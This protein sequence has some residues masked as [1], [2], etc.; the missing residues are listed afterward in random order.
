MTTP[1]N[2]I[3]VLQGV[4]P[5]QIATAPVG[6]KVVDLYD[7]NGNLFSTSQVA[8]MESGGGEVLGYFSIGEAENF[9]SYFSTLPSSIVGPVDPDW[10]GDY[11]VAYW[12]PQWLTV[13]ENYIQTMI[14]QGYNGAFFDVV[15]EAEQSWAIKNVP[16][17]TF[18]AAEGAMV[19]L[20]QELA[21]Y[22]HAQDPNFKIWINSGGAEDMLGDSR[23]QRQLVG[24]RHV[25]Q[26]RRQRVD[27]DRHQR[28][29]DRNLKRSHFYACERGPNGSN[30]GD[31]RY[32]PVGHRRRRKCQLGH[33]R[34]GAVFIHQD[35]R[36]DHGP[37][38]VRE[39]H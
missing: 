25:V 14:N 2:G 35:N 28:R 37:S 29:R 38:P 16:G 33:Q 36:D 4:V 23:R 9:R 1:V 10:P 3:Y 30:P 18:A 19:T 39:D 34:N 26:A 7:D 15:G 17:G 24:S 12:T 11:Q 31:R 13:S 5:S 20:I 32:D 8:Q 22:A 21:N 27:R 6:V